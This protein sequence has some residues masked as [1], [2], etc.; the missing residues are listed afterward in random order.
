MPLKRHAGLG[1][2]NCSTIATTY[3]VGAYDAC[4]VSLAHRLGCAL[5]TADRA[6][7]RAFV[8]TPY[9]VEWLGDFLPGAG[10]QT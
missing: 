10:P 5:V 4:Y 1:N 2:P 9:A 6:L 3:A 7:V 8:G